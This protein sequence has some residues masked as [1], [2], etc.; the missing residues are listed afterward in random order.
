MGTLSMVVPQ[1]IGSFLHNNVYDLFLTGNEKQI[2]ESKKNL[3]E[4][5]EMKDLR[6]MH[7]FLV[8]EVCKNSEGT[9]LK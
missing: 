9:F 1:A 6:L 8:L 3:V 2:A 7:Y 4:E 5:F